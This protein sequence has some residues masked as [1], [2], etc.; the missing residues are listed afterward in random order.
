MKSNEPTR[1]LEGIEGEKVSVGDR[2]HPQL[3]AGEVERL[4]EPL[5]PDRGLPE[6]EVILLTKLNKYD[7]VHS[8]LLLDPETKLMFRADRHSRKDAL[9]HEEYDWKVREVG[10]A[11][12]VLEAAVEYRPDE[13]ADIEETEYMQEWIDS[14]VNMVMMFDDYDVAD[15]WY[16]DWN[17]MNLLDGE[18]GRKGT[19]T[20]R[21]K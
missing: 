4:G 19:A 16:L 2:I 5:D 9:T 15:N 18:S 1:F 6:T 3:V 10:R 17:S 11:I 12:E 7:N 14:L 8:G 21:L 20:I 13:D